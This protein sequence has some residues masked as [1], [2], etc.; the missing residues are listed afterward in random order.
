M[1][2]FNPYNY[3]EYFGRC[4]SRDEYGNAD[5][6]GVDMTFLLG[7]NYE[8]MS[9]V[10]Q[11]LNRLADFEDAEEATDMRGDNND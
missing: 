2:K 5:I 7:L 3:K 8:E 4:T 6:K 10:Q 9:I 11:A 1:A